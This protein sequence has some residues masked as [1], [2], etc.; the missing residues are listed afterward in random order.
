MIMSSEDAIAGDI[1]Q[2]KRPV[3]PQMVWF[4]RVRCFPEDK[5]RNEVLRNLEFE[6]ILTCTAVHSHKGLKTV[7]QLVVLG[8]RSVGLPQHAAAR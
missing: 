6:R 8:L 7:N 2:C 3:Q 4:A 1:N 5:E